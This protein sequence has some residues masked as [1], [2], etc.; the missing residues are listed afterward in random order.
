MKF[1]REHCVWEF[2]KTETEFWKEPE[3]PL[4]EKIKELVT[5]DQPEWTGTATE[6]VEIL[7]VEMQPNALSRKLNV[8][9]ERLILEYGI[10]YK[11]EW[12]HDGRKIRLTFVGKQ[13]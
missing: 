3:D 4:L 12:G 6:L 11:T 2:T 9:L 8:S 13:A 10:Q 7:Q 5:I 1:N